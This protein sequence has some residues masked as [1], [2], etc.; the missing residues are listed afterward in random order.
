MYHKV[1]RQDDAEMAYMRAVA[2]EPEDEETFATLKKIVEDSGKE[3]VKVVADGEGVLLINR[4]TRDG[5]VENQK[6]MTIPKKQP[7]HFTPWELRSVTTFNPDQK[8]NSYTTV[9]AKDMTESAMPEWFMPFGPIPV[10]CPNCSTVFIPTRKYVKSGGE[11]LCHRCSRLFRNPLLES[12]S[13]FQ[14]P[15]QKEQHT[16][17]SA[18]DL[19][20]LVKC[21]KCGAH[22]PRG[23]M[24]RPGGKIRC[25]RCSN[26]W[27]WKPF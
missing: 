8:D 16:T 19:P 3:V 2:F 23:E 21:P 12:K 15:F 17:T 20:D 9:S 24:T 18:K 5:K 1:G 4:R 13:F 22:T 27:E 7:Q 11:I 25:D 10:T 6:T 26:T 14:H